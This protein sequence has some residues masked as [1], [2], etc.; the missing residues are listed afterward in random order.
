MDMHGF[1]SGKVFDAYKYLGAHVKEKGVTFRTFAPN[2]LKIELIGEFNNWNGIQMKRADDDNFFECT[3]ENAKPGMLYKYKI[4]DKNGVEIEQDTTRKYTK[5]VQQMLDIQKKISASTG[6]V[7]NSTGGETV[8]IGNKIYASHVDAATGDISYTKAEVVSGNNLKVTK[9]YKNEVVV[10]Y[11][12]KNGNVLR[13]GSGAPLSRRESIDINQKI[14]KDVTG[15]QTISHGSSSTVINEKYN[16]EYETIF[17]N[18]LVNISTS[19]YK[20]EG[21]LRK[22]AAK[23][24]GEKTIYKFSEYAQKGHDHFADKIDGNQ[25]IENDGTIARDMDPAFAGLDGYK[26][27]LLFGLDDLAGVQNI[28]GQDAR[29]YVR[30]EILK[31]GRNRRTNKLTDSNID[32]TMD[33]FYV[34]DDN[35][36]IIGRVDGSGA[37]SGKN[38]INI[39]SVSGGIAYDHTGRPIGHV[40]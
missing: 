15:T 14:R 40:I 37:I 21:D 8:R 16:A 34:A 4:Y 18:G 27:D 13:D 26:G 35:G 39:G 29:N 36:N 30:D 25:I 31:K 19:G 3:I 38:G 10:E 11:Q 12:D 2:A 7:P 17:D 6:A 33:S 24:V 9:Y 23:T 5:H 1:Y 22:G 20:T 32:W 28:K